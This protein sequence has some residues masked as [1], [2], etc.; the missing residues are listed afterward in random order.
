LAVEEVEEEVE[1]IGGGL[2]TVESSSLLANGEG[3]TSVIFA[4]AE[5]ASVFTDPIE[6]WKEER[7]EQVP[8]ARRAKRESK[9]I[10]GLLDCRLKTKFEA[11]FHRDSFVACGRPEKKKALNASV[12]TLFL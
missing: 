4:V 10:Q 3:A 2:P 7:R 1:E 5:D 6:A 9:S 8:R 11:T 12:V